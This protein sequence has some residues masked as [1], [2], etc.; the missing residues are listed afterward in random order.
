VDGFKIFGFNHIGQ[1]AIIFVQTHGDVAHHVLD[2]LGIVVAR[3]VTY[4]SSG[5]LSS[6]YSSQEASCLN[7]LDEFFD[8]HKTTR[9]SADGDVGTLIVRAVLEIFLEQGHRLVT[10]Q[11]P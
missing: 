9:A 7:D 4:F 10:V 6:P 3:S 11:P 1:D 2:E 5:R 8:P